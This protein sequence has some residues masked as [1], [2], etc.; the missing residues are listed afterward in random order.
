MKPQQSCRKK[1]RTVRAGKKKKM[2]NR[3][4]STHSNVDSWGKLIV[5]TPSR[6]GKRG[7]RGMI[8]PSNSSIRK[9]KVPSRAKDRNGYYKLNANHC[10]DFYEMTKLLKYNV[11]KLTLEAI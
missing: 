9:E 4:K 8:L 11:A 5:E 1:I 6:T 7:R 10:D 2:H 3:K